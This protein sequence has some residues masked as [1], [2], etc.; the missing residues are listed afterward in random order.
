[1]A[2]AIEKQPGLGEMFLKD[3]FPKDLQD[4]YSKALQTH[5]LGQEIATTMAVNRLVNLLG[6]DFFTDMAEKFQQDLE[7]IWLNVLKA[8]RDLLPSFE[9]ALGHASRKNFI[10]EVPKI[11]QAFQEAMTQTMV[12][13]E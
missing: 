10:T 6:P 12:S 3:Y 7:K 9:K 5:L 8:S 2:Q 13:G 4:R 1:V 11:Q